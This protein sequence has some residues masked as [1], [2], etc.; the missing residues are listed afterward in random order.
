MHQ[1][2][3]TNVR[4][5]LAATAI[6]AVLSGD[7]ATALAQREASDK[8]IGQHFTRA[9]WYGRAF[10]GR[11]T[12]SGRIFNQNELTAAHRT[13]RLGSRVRVTELRGGRSVVV[14]ITDRGPYVR[15]R[16]IDLSYAAARHIGIVER[17]VAPVRVEPIAA[18]A[19]AS[20][21]ESLVQT[22]E[23]VPEI[24]ALPSLF[25]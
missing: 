1:L 11:R 16:G 2:G 15:G 13:L 4:Y 6:A 21:D 10:H 12:A 22:S 7:A 25:E 19:V 5:L 17:G 20:T 3:S 18:D 14:R 8:S 9:S 24:R 23:S